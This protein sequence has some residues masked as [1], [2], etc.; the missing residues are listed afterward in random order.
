[1]GLAVELYFDGLTE[2]RL[3][4]LEAT[5]A[6][7]LPPGATGHSAVRPHLSLTLLPDESE[8]VLL[9][10]V[11]AFARATP[12][13]PIA[14][15]AIGLF[16][17]GEGVLYLAPTPTRALLDLHARFHARL[18]RAR[19]AGNPYYLPEHWVPHCTLATGLD[20]AQLA[21]AIQRGL[22]AFP[23]PAA[24]LV[25]VG[26]IRYHP[27]EPLRSFPLGRHAEPERVGRG[28]KE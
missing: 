3:R 1:M 5:L 26:L 16:P 22:A 4:R 14:L 7:H 19:L 2:A 25:E 17:T 28:S 9:P 20:P 23:L 18:A 21:S 15:S 12:R 10:L 11:E 24:T 13:Q 8:V 27:V 6:A